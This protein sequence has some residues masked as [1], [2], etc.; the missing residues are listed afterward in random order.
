MWFRLPLVA[1]RSLAEILRIGRIWLFLPKAGGV[2]ISYWG[3]ESYPLD[4]HAR[5]KAVS[6]RINWRVVRPHAA[7]VDAGDDSESH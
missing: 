5:L 1:N 4:I 6:P 3:M 7:F 2:F